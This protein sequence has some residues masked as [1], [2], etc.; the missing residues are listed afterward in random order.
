VDKFEGAS[1]GFTPETRVPWDKFEMISAMPDGHWCSHRFVDGIRRKANA[2]KGFNL[3]V[4]DI[5]GTCPLN[6]AK[7]VL[8]DY[9][10]MMYTTKRH[11]VAYDGKPA[12]DRY[13][14]VLPMSHVLKLNSDD[15]EEFMNNVLE[16]LPFE[17]DEE[18]GQIN[19]KWL[20]NAGAIHR[21][22]GKLFDVLPFIPKTKKNEDRKTQFD[23]I[24]SM[25][26]LERYFFVRAQDGNRNNILTKYAFA[27]LDAGHQLDD[28]VLRVK[29]FNSKLPK[30]LPED[31]LDK[32]VVQSV[33]KKFF[34]RG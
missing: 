27:L 25:D 15:Y 22:D 18:T 34:Q 3:L 14:I 20:C 9:N 8:K 31:E 30:P 4:L 13:R 32:T 16:F 11:Q 7:N 24:G 28:L 10:Y 5:D 23:A 19:R 29:S 2:I 17:T 12:A 33:T 21:N 6:Q 26:K 1:T